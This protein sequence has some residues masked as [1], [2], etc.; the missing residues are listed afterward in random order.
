MKAAMAIAER[1]LIM[2]VPCQL[3]SVST[4]FLS[5]P[6]A[7]CLA[8][9]GFRTSSLVCNRVSCDAEIV[10][11]RRR[12]ET[13]GLERPIISGALLTETTFEGAIWFAAARKIKAT[14]R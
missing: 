1:A 4:R 9:P 3:W 5:R 14:S 6:D 12:R 13:F 2:T 11:S 7:D 8:K 10:S